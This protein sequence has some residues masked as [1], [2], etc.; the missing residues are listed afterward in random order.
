MIAS[1][2]FF[3]ERR[4]VSNYTSTGLTTELK[5]SLPLPRCALILPDSSGIVLFLIVKALRRQW[6]NAW[7]YAGLRDAYGSIVLRLLPGRET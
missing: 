7:G 6:R 2:T 4:A 5:K 1:K 3:T